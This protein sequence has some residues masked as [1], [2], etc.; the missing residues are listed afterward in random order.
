MR[1]VRISLFAALAYAA[2][3]QIALSAEFKT[4]KLKDRR[5]IESMTGEIVEGDAERLRSA[6]KAANDTGKL[7]ESIRLNSIGGNLL[8]GVKLAEI[9]RFAKMTTNVS[10][11]AVCASACFLLFAAGERKFANYTAQIG[12]HGA[13]DQ[14]GAE[15]IQS[16]AATVSMA[17]VAKELGVPDSII[18]R[19]VVTP[20]GDMVWLS[21]VDLQSMG[22]TMV[23]KPSQLPT[24]VSRSNPP[25]QIPPDSQVSLAQKSE[26]KASQNTQITWKDFVDVVSAISAKQNDGTPKL[27]RGCQPELKLCISGIS[28][29]DKQ[30]KDMAIKVVRDM[31][32]KIVAREICELNPTSDIRLCTDW[33]RG[34]SHRDMKDMHG[35]WHKVADE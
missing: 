20:P 13:A 9:V 12:V 3:N 10:S 33:D 1:F 15:T 28:Y 32:E 5:L 30:N 7:L 35:E 16:N 14:S 27:F 24:E 2:I 18:G 4:S 6:I 23:G 8:E 11:S 34:T 21:P 22:T 25:Q 31:N 19:M 26:T 17:K 29:R